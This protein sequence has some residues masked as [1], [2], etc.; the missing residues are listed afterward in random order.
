M[1]LCIVMEA[2]LCRSV[3]PEVETDEKTNPKA[4]RERS[5]G[6][7]H[8]ADHF[9]GGLLCRQAARLVLME[10]LTVK[11]I[12]C[13]IMICALMICAAAAEETGVV[14]NDCGVNF[15]ERMGLGFPITDEMALR[16]GDILQTNAGSGVTAR[17]GSAYLTLNERAEMKIENASAD[18]FAVT[19]N[20]GELFVCAPKGSA[21][22]VTIAD[23]AMDVSDG[24]AYFTA[25]VGSASVSMLRGSVPDCGEGKTVSY[26]GDEIDT[27]DFSLASLNEFALKQVQS[28]LSLMQLCVT[29]QDI[30]TVIA[31]RDAQRQSA[32]DALDAEDD[33]RSDRLYCTLEIRCDTILDHMD[34]LEAGKD[35]YVP[36][37]GTILTQVRMAFDDGETV[38]DVLQHACEYADIQ[39]EYSWTPMYNSYYVEGIN[40]LYEFDCGSESGWMY[41]VNG[42][43]PNYGCS[44]YRLKDGDSIVWCYTCVGLGADVGGPMY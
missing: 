16:N 11:R 5:D 36:A 37:D 1:S 28:A 29:D 42:W 35:S 32:W 40:Q 7:H 4:R 24:A 22:R 15:V 6:D 10:V 9:C 21:V 3:I 17:V 43:F 25:R 39:L 31:D 19:L 20:A 23:H 41:K 38:F 44:E 26:V 12:I 30:K 8:C 13:I 2:T 18:E 34:M 27:A 14:Y 33:S